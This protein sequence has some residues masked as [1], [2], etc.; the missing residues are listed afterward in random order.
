MSL[1]WRYRWFVAAAGITLACAVVS[2]TVHKSDGL[3]AFADIFQL[4]LMLAGTAVMLANAISR[5]RQERSFWAL[6]TLGFAL[7]SLN[8]ASWVYWECVLHH[9]I[10]DPFFFDIIL[11]IHM[12][13]MIAAVA[14]RP[15]IAKR[16]WSVRLS[17]LNFLTL[18]GWWAFLYA[19]IVFPYQYISPKLVLYNTYYD[20]L[21]AWENGLFLAVLALAV[22]TASGGWRRLYLSFLVAGAIYAVNSQL[23]DR[24]SA[25]ELYYSGSPYDIALIGTTAWMIAAA[26]SA[27]DWSLDSAEFQFHPRWKKLVPQLAM[28]VI[29]SLP[30]LGLWTAAM[31]RSEP[32]VRAFRICAV[33]GAMVFLGAFVFMRQYFQDQAVMRLLLDSRRGYESQK[34]LQ[35]QLVQKEKL[36]TLGHLVA[37]AAREI[38][39]PLSAIMHYSEQLWSRPQLS[40][41]QNKLLRKIIHQAQRT[42]DLVANLLSFAQQAPG[43]KSQVDLSMLLQRGVQMLEARYSGGKIRVEMAIAA[44]LPRVRG[45]VNQIFQIFVEITENAMDALQGAGG[46]VLKISAEEQGDD[47]VIQFS[48]SGPGI[49]EPER[50]FDPFYTTK[51]IGKGTG[52]GLSVVYGVVQDHGGNIVCQNKPEGGALFIVRLPV[53]AAAHVA[54]ASGD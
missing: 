30:V 47:V 16:Q 36:A 34:R 39:H 14:W 40:D 15:D 28:L 7:W 25:A 45:N 50:V 32:A 35:S 18:L 11:F 1:F 4:V 27:R 10:P 21:Y 38:E 3:T 5:P 29:L 49:R 52:L 19:F 13:P 48:D 42:R 24:A 53:T 46:G 17:A 33:L 22:W 6:M 26:L 23:L 8:Q 51:P 54:G 20:R 12:V 31:D 43:E 9:T 2:F 41:E 44:G 37:G